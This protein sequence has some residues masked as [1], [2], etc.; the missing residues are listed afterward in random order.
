MFCG[1]P[2][3]KVVQ[4][5]SPVPD[6]SLLTRF[7]VLMAPLLVLHVLANVKSYLWLR[8]HLPSWLVT[9]LFGVVAAIALSCVPLEARPFIY[10]QF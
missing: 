4:I 3:Q 7:S 10:F 8:A 6:W 5:W 2:G 9:L 1:A